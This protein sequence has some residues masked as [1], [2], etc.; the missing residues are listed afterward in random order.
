MRFLQRICVYV[1]HCPLS[2]P[3][4][5]SFVAKGFR[6][7]LDFKPV[8]RG[9]PNYAPRSYFVNNEKLYIFSK[10]LLYW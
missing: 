1:A 6:P 9:S 10:N 5:S 4:R 8:L 2:S 3:D 7:G